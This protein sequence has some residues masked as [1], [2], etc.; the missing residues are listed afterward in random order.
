MTA[1]VPF[2]GDD[3]TLPPR[4]IPTL[5]PR[6][7]EDANS[8]PAL[9]PHKGAD[10][11]GRQARNFDPHTREAPPKP[12]PPSPDLASI[13]EF[14]ELRRHWRNQSSSKHHSASTL[15]QSLCSLAPRI[16]EPSP[17]QPGRLPTHTCTITN[18]HCTPITSI[19]QV[20]NLQTPRMQEMF[21]ISL[22][23]MQCPRRQ[24]FGFLSH[25]SVWGG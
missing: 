13:P 21:A 5:L 1:A 24:V 15:L 10:H 11:P 2:S 7:L 19:A 23:V 14:V 18:L 8:S 16:L 12:P 6:P 20:P 9:H 3:D 22:F 17:H 25:P 4:P